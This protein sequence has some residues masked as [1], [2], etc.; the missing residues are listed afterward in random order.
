MEVFV[1]LHY[2]FRRYAPGNEYR[3]PFAVTVGGGAVIKEV[4][5]ALG[6]PEQKTYLLFVGGKRAEWDTP[7][8]EGDAVT[9]LPP[10][11]GG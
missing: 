7:L 5:T 6:L 1:K 4:V 9:I 8:G 3:K 2:V 10:I 11:I